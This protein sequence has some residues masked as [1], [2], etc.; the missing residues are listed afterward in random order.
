MICPIS[1]ATTTTDFTTM[2][3][4]DQAI[5]K[6]LAAAGVP[7][8]YRSKSQQLIRAG[9]WGER[10]M[11]AIC[12]PEGQEPLKR[13]LIDGG[14]VELV[15]TSADVTDAFYLAARSLIIK[16]CPLKVVNA[17][18]FPDQD[19][20]WLD[21]LR[22]SRVLAIEGVTFGGGQ[23]TTPDPFGDVRPSIEWW[24]M[25]WLN[26]DRGIIFLS[27]G[28][29]CRDEAWSERFRNTVASRKVAL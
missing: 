16:R 29:I 15:G 12:P 11:E 3:I 4:P 8:R 28:E 19:K 10:L 23:S 17:L 27:D 7:K 5:E 18:S 24:L 14:V 20:D 1:R 26:D 6:A 2:K 25:H 21:S 9:K 13:K 22:E